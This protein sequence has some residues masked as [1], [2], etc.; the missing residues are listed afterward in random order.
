MRTDIKTLITDTSQ[1]SVGDRVVTITYNDNE[2]TDVSHAVVTRLLKTKMTLQFTHIC[3]DFNG[4][5][6]DFNSSEHNTYTEDIEYSTNL[7]YGSLTRYKHRN[8]RSPF[9]RVSTKLYA[10][11]PETQRLSQWANYVIAARETRYK[12]IDA[13]DQLRI[14]HG[15]HK[16]TDLYEIK[17]LVQ[18]IIDAETTAKNTEDAALKH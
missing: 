8:D 7:D 14:K 18:K 5:F 16:T 4:G 2:P 3:V 9:S 15:G 10:E 1:L 6:V 17:G 12:L 13:V 11:G